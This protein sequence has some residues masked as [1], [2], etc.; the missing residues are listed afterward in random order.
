MNKHDIWKFDKLKVLS[1]GQQINLIFSNNCSSYFFQAMLA[2]GYS[3]AKYIFRLI[4]TCFD[5]LL[6]DNETGISWTQKMDL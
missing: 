1:L 5:I 4:L 6:N 2:V 3:E